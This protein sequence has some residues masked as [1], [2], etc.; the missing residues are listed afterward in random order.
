MM[1]TYSKMVYD[2]LQG[3]LEEDAKIPGVEDAFANGKPCSELYEQMREAYGRVCQRLET[4]EDRDL[5]I[6]IA[7]LTKISEL[8]G[9]EMFRLGTVFGMKMISGT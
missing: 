5:E 2:T 9:L 3:V 6:V 4:Q 1:E 8:L 7:S